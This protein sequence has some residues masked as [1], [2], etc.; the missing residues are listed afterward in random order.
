MSAVYSLSPTVTERPASA[1]LVNGVLAISTHATLRVERGQ[2]TITHGFPLPHADS[3]NFGPAPATVTVARVAGL[4]RLILPLV[5]SGWLSHEVLRWL[6]G[7]GAQLVIVDPTGEPIFGSLAPHIDLPELR[8]NQATSAATDHGAAII[9]ELLA[10]KFQ[11]HLAVL[12]KLQDDHPLLSKRQ[13]D[14]ALATAIRSTERIISS[15]IS[16]LDSV[17]RV[18][19][20]MEVEAR[21]AAFYFRCLS[22]LVLHYKK[23]EKPPAQWRAI[24]ERHSPLSGSPQDASS[25]AMCILNYLLGVARGELH[26]AILSAGLDGGIAFLHKD[27]GGALIDDL[28]E[29]LRGQVESWWLDFLTKPL[30]VRDLTELPSG[31]VRL[32][33]RLR[34]ELGE[35]AVL[36]RR[37]ATDITAWLAS[38]LGSVRPLHG[39]HWQPRIREGRRQPRLLSRVPAD[40][41]PVALKPIQLT[42]RL[43]RLCG[44][45]AT[46]DQFC[47][48]ACSQS[49]ATLIALAEILADTSR[50]TP[51]L[52]SILWPALARVPL[53]KICA[54]AHRS[55]AWASRVRSGQL[56]P[57]ASTWRALALAG[58]MQMG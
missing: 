42:Q 16:T 35:T 58:D 46:D 5:G 13:D 49:A 40:T 15:T 3:H 55:K 11:G 14:G 50:R 19:H 1:R 36:W 57:A 29:P 9:R 22:P 56:V 39:Q 53:P 34:V 27:R 23:G 33:P 18:D 43:C 8:R 48:D 20:F 45:L 54:S 12:A 30:S 6:A 26:F 38:E 2:L 31:E 10:R 47:S 21:V 41:P 44:S 32:L 52:W 4:K 51:Q 25:P 17:S 37:P 28:I 24:G 7:V